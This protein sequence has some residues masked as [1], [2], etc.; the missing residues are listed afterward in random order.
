MFNIQSHILDIV[1][2]GDGAAITG[3][4]DGGRINAAIVVPA[5]Y[6]I[7]QKNSGSYVDWIA[8]FTG[9]ELNV[10][11]GIVSYGNGVV[12]SGTNRVGKASVKASAA[13]LRLTWHNQEHEDAQ[14]KEWGEFF[15][16]V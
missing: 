12:A 9:V 13:F 4:S 7:G 15:Y 16:M 5:G 11:E 3:N 14:K 1:G 10:F 6:T 2:T 8:R